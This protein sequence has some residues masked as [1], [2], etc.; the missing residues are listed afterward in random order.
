M[1]RQAQTYR[2]NGAIYHTHLKVYAY[3]PKFDGLIVIHPLGRCGQ[4]LTVGIDGC[5]TIV[6]II[7]S[8]VELTLLANTLYSECGTHIEIVV[9]V[10]TE[11]EVN[12]VYR[13]STLLLDS[14]S[15]ACIGAQ[16]V[17]RCPIIAKFILVS[18]NEVVVVGQRTTPEVGVGII[19]IEY[20]L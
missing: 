14:V 5:L 19:V 2:L 4:G 9:E 18:I 8:V 13:A 15:Y 10:K 16:A 12:L 6:D 3:T 17:C 7:L 20:S 11:G 1:Y